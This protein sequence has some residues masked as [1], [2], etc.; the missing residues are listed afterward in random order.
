MLGGRKNRDLLPEEETMEYLNTG[1][2]DLVKREWLT[3]QVIEVIT[4]GRDP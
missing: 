1:G 4:D 2:K 3:M